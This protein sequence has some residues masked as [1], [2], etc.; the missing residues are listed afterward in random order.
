MRGGQYGPGYAERGL[1]PDD[2]MMAGC[3]GGQER[4]MLRED[5]QS[6]YKWEGKLWKG[7]WLKQTMAHLLILHSYLGVKNT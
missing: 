7:D 3:P 6:M 2:P 1:C 4:L 5:R